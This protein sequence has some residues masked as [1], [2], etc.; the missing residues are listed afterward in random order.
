MNRVWKSCLKTYE[1]VWEG[2]LEAVWEVHLDPMSGDY[3]P[4]EISAEDLFE[5][6]AEQVKDHDLISIDWYVQSQNGSSSLKLEVMPFQHDA[7]KWDTH[8]LTYWTWPTNIETGEPLNWL[9]LPVVDKLWS[10]EPYR[11][12]KGGFIQSATGWKPSIL[13]PFVSLKSLTE[14]RKK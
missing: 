6:W 9:S 13:Q 8:F 4:D 12:D 11:A 7:V 1:R 5:K 3:L 10:V 2:S 14:T